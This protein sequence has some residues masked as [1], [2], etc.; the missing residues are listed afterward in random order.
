MFKKIILYKFKKIN[1]INY[2][3]E[4]IRF[5]SRFHYFLFLLSFIMMHNIVYK[6]KITHHII[7]PHIFFK[8]KKIANV[9]AV[10]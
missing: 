4:F 2:F 9:T 3:Y 6:L 5:F 10:T 1:I 8:Y 7:Q